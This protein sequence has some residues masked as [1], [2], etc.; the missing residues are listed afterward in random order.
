MSTLSRFKQLVISIALPRL[1]L[2]KKRLAATVAFLAR[3]GRP[4]AW[5]TFIVALDLAVRT[6]RGLGRVVWSWRRAGACKAVPMRSSCR[7]LGAGSDQSWTATANDY[8][9]NR[10]TAFASAGTCSRPGPWGNQRSVVNSTDHP[11]KQ[12]RIHHLNNFQSS[13][14]LA[15]WMK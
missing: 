1:E 10:A 4:P 14:P 3:A 8:P 12:G 15:T 6:L 7:V 13:H 11:C 2:E 5:S 9:S